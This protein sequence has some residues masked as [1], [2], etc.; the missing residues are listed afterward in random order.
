M[1]QGAS[2]SEPLRTAYRLT[3]QSEFY[4]HDYYAWRVQARS[5]RF[6]AIYGRHILPDGSRPSDPTILDQQERQD[7]MFARP[8]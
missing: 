8:D 7:V 5:A 1:E 2:N 3:I 4:F 6:V